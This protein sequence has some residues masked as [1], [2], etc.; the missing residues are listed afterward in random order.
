MSEQSTILDTVKTKLIQA[1]TSTTSEEGREAIRKD[2]TKLLDQMDNISKQTNYNGVNLLEKKDTELN[3]QVGDEAENSIGLKTEFSA[4]TEGLGSEAQLI[5]DEETL[6]DLSGEAYIDK[7]GTQLTMKADDNDVAL[8]AGTE[9]HAIVI[10]GAATASGT[11][12]LADFTI[13][14]TKVSAL[15]FTTDGAGA[16]TVTTSDKALIAEFDANATMVNNATLPGVYTIANGSDFAVEFASNVDIT[17]LKITGA[18]MGT[19]GA[20]GSDVVSVVT[21]EFTTVTK[22]GGVG[23]IGTASAE[24]AVGDDA[25]ATLVPTNNLITQGTSSADGLVF[26]GGGAG[27]GPI[28]EKGTMA[29]QFDSTVNLAAANTVGAVAI[30]NQSAAATDEATYILNANDVGQM[31]LA[32]NASNEVM[33]STNDA[34]M[35]AKLDEM[36]ENNAALT[37]INA[38]AY[39]F[40]GTG[41]VTAN[42]DFGGF[43]VKD[44]TI[45]GQNNAEVITVETSEA[46][47][48]TKVGDET[49][50]NHLL[51]TGA[52][53]LTTTKAVT[54]DQHNLIGA[55]AQ[56]MQFSDSLAGLK[57]LEENGLTAEIANK[58]MG[59]VDTALNQLNTLRSDFGSTQIQ[60]ET[61]T[62]N[63]QVTKTNIQAAESVIR[64]VDYA[65]ESANFNKQNII[66]Q[67]GTYAMSQANAMQQNVMRLLQ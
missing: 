20:G 51:L 66:A 1:S 28:V 36:A 19:A 40:K 16:I 67:A 56:G 33:F 15:A 50:D 38:G 17:D 39:S 4:T 12:G 42:L 32:A 46:V 63:M 6:M 44:L 41:G 31:N 62:R 61:A 23:R 49:D 22:D 43:D 9:N 13:E 57:G 60:L 55:N 10:G 14:S 21:D 25:M 8:S 27:L 53:I 48:V 58:Y 5:N 7:A 35:T 52:T 45:S 64:D 26:R 54:A 30:D 59:V 29:V 34:D 3:F 24:Y 18:T 2:I 11:V 47:S 65:S 37:R